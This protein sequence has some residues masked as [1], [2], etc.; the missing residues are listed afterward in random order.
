MCAVRNMAVFCS[1]LTTLFSWYV[2]MVWYGILLL[3]LLL[4]LLIV[5]EVVLVH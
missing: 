5:V 4:L 1:S 3:L 2:G